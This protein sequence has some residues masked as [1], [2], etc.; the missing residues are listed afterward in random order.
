M[1]MNDEP[2]HA[3]SEDDSPYD[4]EGG[5]EFPQVVPVD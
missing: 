5:E 2:S 3:H 1:A 4:G